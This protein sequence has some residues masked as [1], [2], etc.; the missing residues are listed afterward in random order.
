MVL[1]QCMHEQTSRNS[2]GVTTAKETRKHQLTF[3][4]GHKKVALI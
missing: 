2:E 3:I 4:E 1:E